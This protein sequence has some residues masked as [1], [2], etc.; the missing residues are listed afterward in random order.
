MTNKEM[1]RLSK[2]I[3]E[4]ADATVDNFNR[5]NTKEAFASLVGFCRGLASSLESRSLEEESE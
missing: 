5:G 3:N 2:L 1:Q 4:S